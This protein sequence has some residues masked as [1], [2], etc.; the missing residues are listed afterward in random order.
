MRLLTVLLA[1]APA[2]LAR[3]PA[4]ELRAY[5]EESAGAPVAAAPA[6]WR[7]T[8]SF[9][10]TATSGN[11]ETFTFAGGL[12]AVRER[13]P[14]KLAVE[15]DSIVSRSEGE[16]TANEQILTE[17][18]ERALGERGALFQELL[19]EHDE[20]EELDFRLQLTLGYQRRLVDRERFRLWG[21]AGGGVLHEEFRLDPETEGV[22]RF[23]LR[24]EWRITDQLLFTQR[25]AFDPSLSRGGEFRLLS[26]SV[27]STPVGERVD[28]RLSILDTFDSD[29]QPGVGRNDV[30]IALTL[31][32]AFTRKRRDVKTE[33][34]SRAP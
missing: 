25:F 24:F 15:A 9:G 20:Q 19:G 29:P 10:L 28:L 30:K 12:E 1:L 34:G 26:E 11:A 14:W 7:I 31:A 27:F 16:E 23:G 33:T 8:G 32:I 17:R 2:A 4:A 6:V 13:A 22:L 21:E 3:P 5:L 18:L